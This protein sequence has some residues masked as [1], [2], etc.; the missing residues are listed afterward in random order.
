MQHDFF[1][2]N[3]FTQVNLHPLLQVRRGLHLT[4]VTKLGTLAGRVRFLLQGLNVGFKCAQLL[5]ALFLN[6]AL[7]ATFFSTQS[8]KIL[9]QLRS[10]F[11]CLRITAIITLG[12][13]HCCKYRLQAIIVFLRIGIS[14][15]SV[16]ASALDSHG[17][18]G[19]ED[20][21]NHVVSVQVTSH[22]PVYLRFRNLGMSDEVPRSRRQKPEAKDPILGI[23]VE[24]VSSN[25][26]LYK[27]SIWFV[28]I[29]RADNIIT[30]GPRIWP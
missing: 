26:L 6:C 10:A 16:T 2:I 13:I 9:C 12:L 18:E 21:G 19:I 15:V 30:I 17:A 4:V 27:P 22:L 3:S 1:N 8:N 29:E 11:F 24:T 23:R 14:L 20:I 25:L 7:N 5:S 28:L